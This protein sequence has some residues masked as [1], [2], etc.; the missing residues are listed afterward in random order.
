VVS[1]VMWAQW[2]CMQS[3]ALIRRAVV[4]LEE[5]V[6]LG[7]GPGEG[8]WEGCGAGDAWFVSRQRGG[9]WVVSV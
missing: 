2:W 9:L 7:L 6:G 1:L 3:Y 8:A 4:Q 5:R